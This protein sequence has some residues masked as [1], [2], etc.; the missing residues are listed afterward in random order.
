[1]DNFVD[2]GIFGLDVS[3]YQDDNNTPQG[4]DFERMKEVGTS[5]VIPKAGQLNYS[6]ED[7]RTN[8]EGA[9]RAGIPRGSYW[10]C[11]DSS[12]GVSQARKYWSLIKDDT[13]EGIHAADYENGSW[14]DWNQL[15][16]FISEFQQLSG[17]PN[18]RIAI[19]TGY[20]YWREFSPRL[21]YQL[22]WF[23]KYKLCIAR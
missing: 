5:F 20:Y 7:F 16:N 17:F 21:T 1:M 11:D 3:W 6:D 19:Y 18:E 8:W 2:T 15:Y 10:F 13:G 4:I 23:G 22:E 9:K 12:N 14:T